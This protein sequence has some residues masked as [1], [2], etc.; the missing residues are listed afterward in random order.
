MSHEIAA[1]FIVGGFIMCNNG[2]KADWYRGFAIIVIASII[3]MA[4][5]P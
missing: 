4:G 5:N 1:A 2:I 3:G